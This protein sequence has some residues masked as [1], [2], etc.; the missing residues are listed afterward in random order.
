MKTTY[1]LFALVLSLFVTSCAVNNVPRETTFVKNDAKIERVEDL[2]E[3]SVMLYNESEPVNV[4]VN[5]KIIRQIENGEYVV[6]NLKEGNHKFDLRDANNSK[7][8]R[9]VDL[10]VGEHTK[11]IEIMPTTVSNEFEIKNKLPLLWKNFRYVGSK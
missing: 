1:S 4:Y 6:L 7:K 11:V 8:R 2:R 9:I 10:N 5:G 3:G